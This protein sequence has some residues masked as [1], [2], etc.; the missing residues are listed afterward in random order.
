MNAFVFWK[1]LDLFCVHVFLEDT[2]CPA[3]T[4]SELY[5]VA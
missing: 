5:I 3:S 4:L 2:G 1:I